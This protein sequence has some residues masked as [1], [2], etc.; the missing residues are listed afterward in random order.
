MISINIAY[1]I[2]EN[3]SV[4][5]SSSAAGTDKMKVKKIINTKLNS[6]EDDIKKDE[7]IQR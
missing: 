7:Y 3:N 6:P 2:S 1:R 4:Q 5:E